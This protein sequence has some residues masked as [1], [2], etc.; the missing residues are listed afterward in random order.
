MAPT[1][2][3]AERLL[4]QIIVQSASD[5]QPEVQTT[6]LAQLRQ[7]QTSPL[8]PSQQDRTDAL[9]QPSQDQ[10][11]P[12]ARPS[13]I[14]TIPL[15]PAQ[16]AGENAHTA[17]VPPFGL[18]FT[19]FDFPSANGRDPKNFVRKLEGLMLMQ[20][21]EEDAVIAK[22]WPACVDQNSPAD[23]WY[24]NLPEAT[25][26]S[27]K[28]LKDAYINRFEEDAGLKQEACLERLF[29][30]PLRDE[31]LGVM[32]PDGLKHI[33]W[34]DKI[35]AYSAGCPPGTSENIK[36]LAAVNCLGPLLKAQVKNRTYNSVDKLCDHI[37]N[38][39]K[40][41]VN[42]IRNLSNAIRSSNTP[43]ARAAP[44]QYMQNDVGSVKAPAARPN[45]KRS[46]YNA[47]SYM[48]VPAE[49]QRALDEYMRQFGNEPTLANPPP[50]MGKL[51][52]GTKECWNCAMPEPFGH[53][54]NACP[55]KRLPAI[56]T[57]YRALYATRSF[58][59]KTPPFT[60]GPDATQQMA[61][62]YMSESSSGSTDSSNHVG[63]LDEVDF[64]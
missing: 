12:P 18:P 46:P 15:L 44:S 38:L 8:A 19:M 42:Y 26:L 62:R 25:K 32:G 40:D 2:R 56:E 16:S 49:H 20:G 29:N 39:T 57:R 10:T 58:G 47:D 33:V 51:P 52:P 14:S 35:R 31:E 50:L 28:L 63:W 54:A 48:H 36:V 4:N 21:K 5:P 3:S 22:V 60:T 9:A 64:E 1:T 37:K 55:N 23:P 11:G 6:P 61:I 59:Q 34:Q 30:T 53:R 17:P 27:H 41:D 7:D 13:H 24:E 43:P 45:G